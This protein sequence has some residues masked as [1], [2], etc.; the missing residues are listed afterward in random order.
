MVAKNKK[1][2]WKKE[3]PEIVVK[4]PAKVEEVIV[5]E[6][7]TPPARRCECG[8]FANPDSH[9]CWRCSHRT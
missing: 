9:Q 5:P 6:P 4:T 2:F 1:T 7:E 8:D 3:E